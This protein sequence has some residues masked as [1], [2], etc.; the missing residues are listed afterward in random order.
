MSDSGLTERQHQGG[1]ERRCR[2]ET[3]LG[4]GPPQSTP[5]ALL[6]WVFAGQGCVWRPG[7]GCDGPY[8]VPKDSPF[9]THLPEGI[10]HRREYSSV[11]ALLLIPGVALGW[12]WTLLAN[13]S[14][15]TLGRANH[16]SDTIQDGADRV[17]LL[18]TA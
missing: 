7:H 4:P 16:V 10:S 2:T 15:D 3:K 9:S 6:I 17:V 12:K 8:W 1:R 11:S 18:A 14:A 13:L 5:G